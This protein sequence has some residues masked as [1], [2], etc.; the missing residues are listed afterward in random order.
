MMLDEST[1]LIA[2][3]TQDDKTIYPDFLEKIQEEP[4]ANQNPLKGELNNLPHL[5]HYSEFHFL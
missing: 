2:I 5:S 1:H 3:A 4:N